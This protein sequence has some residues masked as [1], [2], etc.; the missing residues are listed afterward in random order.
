MW[1]LRNDIEA[2]SNNNETQRIIYLQ[3]ILWNWWVYKII[4][5]WTTSNH[6]S[7]LNWL[8]HNCSIELGCCMILDSAKV[9]VFSCPSIGWCK[10]INFWIS[11][12]TPSRNVP[13]CTKTSVL[14]FLSIWTKVR[15]CYWALK[16]QW[17]KAL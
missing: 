11:F 15:G 12:G 10:K 16:F 7:M 14:K 8:M 6:F 4:F 2:D 3:L 13:I 5:S 9:S 1:Y 17:E